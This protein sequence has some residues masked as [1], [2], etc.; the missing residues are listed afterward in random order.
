MVGLFVVY[1]KTSVYQSEC[2]DDCVTVETKFE[3]I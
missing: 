3:G 1:F 2:D